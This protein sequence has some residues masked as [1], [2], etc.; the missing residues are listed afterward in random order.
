M[1]MQDI[2]WNQ[3]PSAQQFV[4]ELTDCILSGQSVLLNLPDWTPWYEKLYDTAV[5]ELTRL[6]PYNSVETL[7]CPEEDFG[8][9][10]LHSEF[11][12]EQCRR[13]YRPPESTA[14]FLARS[15]QIALNSQYLWVRNISTQKLPLLGKFIA[16]YHRAAPASAPRA[17]FLLEVRCPAERVQLFKGVHVMDLAQAI[18]P[19]D[20]YMFCALGS[21]QCGPGAN[22]RPYLAETVAALCQD[23]IEL[24]ALCLQN[25]QQ[26]W[27]D[28][29]GTVQQLA[30]SNVRANG[31]AFAILPG[32]GQLRQRLWEAQIKQL[33]PHIEKYRMAF[34]RRHYEELS[35]H[36]PAQ[37]RLH[38]PVQSPDELEIGALYSC[39][40]NDE[41]LRLSG[42]EYEE[43]KFFRNCRNLLAHLNP[44]CSADVQRCLQTPVE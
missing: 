6:N 36:L 30:Q 22:C 21:A 40:T 32:E 23:E 39:Y 34:I 8:Q 10:L 3:I 15:N 27:T 24:C 9:Y 2:W 28:P 37:N 19:F 14:A 5:A 26:F 41:A 20:S 17:V 11:C 44:L 43:L 1:R 12:S 42:E 29:I 25:W 18:D 13:T 16:E 38:E 7:D 33:F 31:S 35:L 4:Q